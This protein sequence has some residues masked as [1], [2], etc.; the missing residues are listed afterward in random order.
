LIDPSAV[1][2]AVGPRT[3]AVIAVHLFGRLA[4]MGALRRVADERRLAL[5]EDAAHAAGVDEGSGP[6]G[7][8]G[9]AA[10][11]SFYPTKPLGC[12]GDG[13]AVCSSDQHVLEAVR[14]L[15]SYGWSEWHGQADRTGVNS[16]LDEIQAA[17]LRPRLARLPRTHARLLSLAAIYRAELER[18]AGLELPAEPAGTQTPWHQFVV[19]SEDR[20]RVR[21]TLSERGVG[22]AVH[23]QP[24]PHELHVFAG[25]TSGRFAL[26]RGLAGRSISLPFDSWLTDAQV[27]FVAAAL[28]SA[29]GSCERSVT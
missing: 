21:A 26:A 3:A 14:R 2:A 17:V 27:E 22:T 20:D 23:Y 4:P 28:A 5:I 9:D 1:A 6:A 12:L 13:G 11:F 15:R 8:L 24:L 29:I 7:S 19:R 18:C 25:R 10:A 16:R